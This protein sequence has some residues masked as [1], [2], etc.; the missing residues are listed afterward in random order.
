MFFL[1]ISSLFLLKILIVIFSKVL[2][3]LMNSFFILSSC[4]FILETLL[5]K[6]S[7]SFANL[8]N[9]IKFETLEKLILFSWVDMLNRKIIDDVVITSA[10]LYIIILFLDN[11]AIKTWLVKDRCLFSNLSDTVF[12]IK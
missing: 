9:V 10:F 11:N 3:D 7:L 8:S 1:L 2:F 4:C 12:Y 6:Y 5:P